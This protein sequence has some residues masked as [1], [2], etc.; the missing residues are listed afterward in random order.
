MKKFKKIFAVLLTLAMVLGMSMTS[1]AAT[2]NG[3]INVTGLKKESTKVSIYNVVKLD[4]N[5][6]AWEIANWAKNVTGAIDSTSDP[7]KINAVEL[8]K[9][10]KA[11]SIEADETKT[12]TDGTA[13]FDILEA[14]VYLVIAETQAD[15][16]TTTYNPMLAVT[17]KYE[18]NIMVGGEANVVAKSANIQVDKTADTDDTYVAVGM[19]ASFTINTTFPSFHNESGANTSGTYKITDTPTGLSIKADTIKVSVGGVELEEGYTASVN[20]TTGIMTIEFNE[21]YIGTD[22]AH[23]GAA[24]KITYDATVTE[25][26]GIKNTANAYV[27]ETSVGDDEEKVY[28]GTIEMTKTNEDGSAGLSGAE[29]I[30][31]TERNSVKQYAVIT[32]GVVTGW[33]KRETEASH[34]TTG[35]DGKVSVS[36]LDADEIYKFKEVVAPDGYSINTTDS[37]A[38]WK[39]VTGTE[40]TDREGTASMTDTKLSSLPSTGGIGTTIFTIGG[41]AIM[42]IAAAL[43]FASRRKAAK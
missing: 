26:T 28:T 35:A 12:V 24:V 3:E 1:F 18:D 5:D 30:V 9:A 2:N 8:E 20:T 19:D 10:L 43:F 29:F 22:N 7:Y 21:D 33:T 42:I 11:S 34:I 14:G 27:N 4:S 38:E 15:G 16:S 17:Y 32:D 23:A 36:G 39:A 37:T 6:N 40:L 41:C 25:A 13:E 31:Y